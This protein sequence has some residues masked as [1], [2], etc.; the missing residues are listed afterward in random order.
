M[1][2]QR[3]INNLIIQPKSQLRVALYFFSGF[4]I[5]TGLLMIFFTF[6]VQKIVRFIQSTYFLD[7]ELISFIEKYLHTFIGIVFFALVAFS[8]LGFLIWIR[9]SHRIFGPLVPLTRHIKELQSG[10]YSSRVKLREGDFLIELKDELN[11]LAE[12]LEKKS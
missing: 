3:K 1:K 11:L 4:Y 6:S 5:V 7:T 12:N 9:L 8:A 10:N 2:S